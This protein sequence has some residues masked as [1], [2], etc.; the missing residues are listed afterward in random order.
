VTLNPLILTAVLAGATAVGGRSSTQNAS[1]AED[2][3]IAPA[4]FAPQRDISE[5]Y[6][7]ASL[8]A[9]DKGLVVLRFTVNADGKAVEPFTVG[10]QTSGSSSYR[11]IVGAETY[12]RDSTFGTVMDD[13][14]VLTASFVF[15]LAPCGHIEHILIRDYTINFCRDPP[16]APHVLQP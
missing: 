8:R 4:I 2:R 6:F 3:A 5:Y 13:K 7:P 11:L 16:P 14:K 15:E 12:L 10:E 1:S 9:G